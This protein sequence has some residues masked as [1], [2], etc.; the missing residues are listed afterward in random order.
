MQSPIRPNKWFLKFIV[1]QNHILHDT[2]A[3]C[4]SKLRVSGSEYYYNTP[5]CIGIHVDDRFL[6]G[7]FVVENG[8]YED[9]LPYP[10]YGI[11]SYRLRLPIGGTYVNKF[12]EI[13]IYFLH[14]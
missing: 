6:G 11:I 13:S 7:H 14:R 1:D 12:I 8:F 10:I 2:T 4:F 3:L 5:I 9:I